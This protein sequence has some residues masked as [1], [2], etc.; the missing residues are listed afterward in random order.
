MPLLTRWFVRTA[1]VYFVL[2][3]LVGV[4]LMAQNA[5]ELPP[6]VGALSPIYFHLFMVG[7]VT[8]L[9][10]GIGYWL[11]PTY[12]KEKPRGSERLAKATYVLLNLGL[13][14]RAIS[15]PINT[16]TPQALWGWLL[17]LSAIMQWLAGMAFVANSW[18]R[19]KGK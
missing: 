14:L 10:F 4:A 19:I 7:W 1:M 2:A 9:I 5:T 18:P 3:L 17:A 6:A 13:V 16:V 11:F 8:Q 15:E 12:T